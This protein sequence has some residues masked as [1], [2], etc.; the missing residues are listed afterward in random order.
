MA[1]AGTAVANEAASDNKATSDNK[2]IARR[3]LLAIPAKDPVA[4]RSVLAPEAHLTLMIAGV[5][6]PQL[7]AF[8]QG[9]QWDRD[10]MIEMEL[11]F[12][13]RLEGPFSLE[14]LSLI[15]EGDSVAAEAIGKCCRAATGQ[16][17]IQHYSYHFQMSNGRIVDIRLYQDTFHL[18]QVWSDL[19]AAVQPHYLKAAN[20]ADVAQEQTVDSRPDIAAED[21]VAVNKKI[22]RRFLAAVRNRDTEETRV[23]WS[24]EGRWSFAIGGD[25]SPELRIFHGAPRWDREGMIKMQQKAHGNPREPM[26]LDVY[27]L[28]AEGDEISA[29]AVG[30]IVR[31]NGRAYRQHYSFHFKAHGGKLVEGHVYQDTLH[32][33]DVTLDPPDGGPVAVRM[34]S[35]SP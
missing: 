13:R 20:L 7:H 12:Q 34:S 8:P 25:Y 22:V 23:T 31:G 24:S 30:I 2:E 6:S 16:S 19:G 32:Q 3:F 1:E 5:Y 17:Y 11:E 33:Y 4:M 35:V 14:I 9:T 29:E 15:A 21:R 28:L 26:T 10:G 27:S 18:W